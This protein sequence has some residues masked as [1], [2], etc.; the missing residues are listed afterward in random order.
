MARTDMEC[1]TALRRTGGVRCR[2]VGA[3][4][5]RASAWGNRSLLLLVSL[6]A[7]CAIAPSH[8]LAVLVFQLTN[9]SPHVDPVTIAITVDGDRIAERKVAFRAGHG[10]DTVTFE[11]SGGRHT[12]QAESVDGQATAAQEISVD[13]CA[14]TEVAYWYSL[15]ET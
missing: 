7:G 4:R 9:Q 10:Q 14:Y 8:E 2:D 5:R 15:T 13:A 1:G 6:G 11:V 3:L 12:V